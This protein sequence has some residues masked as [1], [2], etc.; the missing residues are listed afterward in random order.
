MHVGWGT[1]ANVGLHSIR[2]VDASMSC[3][4]RS[5]VRAQ[6][7]PRYTSLEDTQDPSQG[8]TIIDAR[9]TSLRRSSVGQELDCYERQKL[10]GKECWGHGIT[11]PANTA[12]ILML[13]LRLST[14]VTAP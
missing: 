4:C 6:I 5:R 9:P 12:A 14:S 3:H 2:E 1:P 13:G 8:R 11:P 10:F 7:L